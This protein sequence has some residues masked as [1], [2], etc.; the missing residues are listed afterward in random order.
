MGSSEQQDPET[1]AVIGA[2]MEV[3]RVLGH[4]FLEPVYQEALAM[5]L[6]ARG[7]PFERE[8]PL[9]ITYKGATLN[10]AYRADFVCY[11]E[12]IVE[13]KAL[14]RLTGVEEAQVIHYL[15]ATGFHRSLLINFGAAQLEHRRLVFGRN[16]HPQ[17]NADSRR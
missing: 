10:C 17:T 14:S 2:A 8:A 5:E 4:G 3:H 13:L 12:I 9:T 16:D 6:K 11:G 7:I 1:Y 15:K